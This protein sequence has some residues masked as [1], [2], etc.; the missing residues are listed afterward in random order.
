MAQQPGP[1]A[2]GK[3]SRPKGTTLDFPRFVTLLEGFLLARTGV[4]MQLKFTNPPRLKL[5]SIELVYVH[6]GVI[7]PTS[8]TGKPLWDEVM[9]TKDIG[10]GDDPVQLRAELYA[11]LAALGPD[12]FVW[13]YG[14]E[15]FRFGADFVKAFNK[16][17]IHGD[18]RKLEKKL[19]IPP[20]AK[21]LDPFT[22]DGIALGIGTHKGQK[23]TDRE[24]HHMTQYLLVQYFRNNNKSVPAWNSKVDYPGIKTKSRENLELFKAEGRKALELK[25]LDD[26]PSIR[27]AG[28]PAILLSADLH[29][30]GRL[31]I[32]REG[33]WSDDEDTDP[34]SKDDQGSGGQSRQGY[35]IQRQFKKALKSKFKVSDEDPG[36]ASAVK[37]ME[38]TTEKPD[39]LI[40]DAM[41]ETYRWMHKIMLP[42]LKHGLLTRELAY[43]RGIAARDHLEPSVT[44]KAQLKAEYDLTAQDMTNVYERALAK[45]DSVMRTAGWPAP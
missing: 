32:N 11:R 13:D 40:Q 39:G 24:S 7:P 34:D 23:G 9:Q 42:A 26:T 16:V 17:R 33:R 4:G 29:K 18:K 12:R 25:S 22:Q 3:G 21:Y 30:R 2:K 37:A 44:G 19:I 15:K 20:K 27:G 1:K 45:N 43:Y 38:A 10:G 28:M 31:H 14:S 35:A 36:W 8:K 5:T 41:I 6:L